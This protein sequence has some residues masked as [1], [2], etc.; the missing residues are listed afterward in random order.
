MRQA[1]LTSLQ[2]V[3]KAPSLNIKDFF[4]KNLW[5]VVIALVT[6]VSTYSLYGYRISILEQNINQTNAR[7][8]AAVGA[9]VQNQI[10]LAEIQ[11]DIEY[12]KLQFNRVF[13]GL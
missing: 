5:A 13:P 6:V 3:T 2:K 4:V 8:E 11:K 12:I 7:L 9:S 10:T 1:V